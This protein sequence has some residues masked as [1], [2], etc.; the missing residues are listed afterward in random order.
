LVSHIKKITQSEIFR[1]NGNGRKEYEE[2]CY[3]KLQIS[4]LY[5]SA[6]VTKM[7]KLT[8]KN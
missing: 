4:Y 7:V 8:R 2:R 6:N 3:G 5:Y 1:E